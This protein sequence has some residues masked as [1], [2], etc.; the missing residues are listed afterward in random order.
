[1]DIGDGLITKVKSI[2]PWWTGNGEL[3]YFNSWLV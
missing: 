1:M 3:R 2:W